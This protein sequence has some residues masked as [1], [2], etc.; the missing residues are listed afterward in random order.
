M[1]RRMRRVTTSLIL[2]LTAA[3]AACGSDP[4]S[5]FS[6]TAGASA[7]GGSDPGMAGAQDGSGGG[8][9]NAGGSNSAGSGSTP[10]GARPAGWLYTDGGKVKLAD[11]KGGGNVW[12]GRGVNTDDLFFCGYNGA[13]WMPNPAAELKT[14]LEN[15]LT[16][17]KPTFIRLSLSMAS[18][19]M[20]V[21]WLTEPDKYQKPMIDVVQSIGKH[22]GVFVLLVLRS[23]A[24]MI[25]QDMQHGDPEATGIPSDSTSSPDKAKFPRGTDPVYEALVDAF[26][27]DKFVM[28][29]LTNEP[30]GNLLS[31]DQIRGSMDHAVATIRAAEDKLKVPHH[32]VSVQGQG[33]TS[34][35][36]FYAAKPLPYDNVVYEIHGYPPAQNSYT[37]ANLPVIIGEYG[38][39]DAG[40]A[41]AF[42]ADIEAKQI[43]SLAWDFDSYSNCA[44][45]LVEVN[46]SSTDLRPTD[47]GKI[48]QGYLL[49][50]APK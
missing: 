27:N 41:P 18:N 46:Q 7:R 45:D 9:A 44:P 3:L 8:N 16:G 48:V 30:G 25:G 11:G 13:L 49:A 31:N 19:P 21:S 20:T 43:P 38:S 1:L 47:W 40:S 12:V 24:S 5:H 4:N 28:F 37:Y 23:D 39:L 32:I 17:W 50:H 15:M 14:V 6:N 10:L 2:T 26:K 35:L 22:D 29:G 42:Y 34:D 36:S 33:W